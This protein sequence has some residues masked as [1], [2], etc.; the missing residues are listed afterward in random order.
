MV[1]SIKSLGKVNKDTQG[2]LLTFKCLDYFFNQQGC[3]M[4]DR[5]ICSYLH[6]FNKD[7]RGKM[8]RRAFQT[9]EG[10]S[11]DLNSLCYRDI[12]EYTQ[13]SKGQRKTEEDPTLKF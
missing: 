13:I 2:L 9:A 8:C 12:N 7:L 11:T 3:S 5:S 6:T 4:T 1:D 10:V